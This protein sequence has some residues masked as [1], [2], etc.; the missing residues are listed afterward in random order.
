MI[1]PRQRIIYCHPQEFCVRA[2]VDK[3]IVKSYF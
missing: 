1:F 3:F 2:I